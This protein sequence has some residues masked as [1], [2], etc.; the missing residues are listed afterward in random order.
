HSS[1]LAGFPHI[2]EIGI[3]KITNIQLDSLV[4]TTTTSIRIYY[5]LDG[6]FQWNIND[7]CYILYPGDLAIILPGQKFGGTKGFMDIGTVCWLSLE[8][9]QTDL[10]KKMIVGNWSGLSKSERLTISKILQLNNTSVLVRVKDAHTILQTI[11]D[12]LSQQE[13]AYA[14]RVNH[15]IDELLILIVRQSTYQMNLRRDFPQTFTKLEQTLREDLARQWTVEEMAAL[16]GL[17]TTAFSEK[18]KNYTGFS[19]LNYLI[20]IRISEAIKLLRRQE[21]SITTIALE[22]GFYSSQHFST[23][24]KKLTGYTPIEFRK[25]T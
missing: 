6:K 21:M 7:R 14:T 17:G 9:N 1:E 18:V 10:H 20:N 15:L 5:I 11:K 8:V 4:T 2:S 3:R 22:T 25:K 16:I 24:F 12:E 23:T 13:V 19:P